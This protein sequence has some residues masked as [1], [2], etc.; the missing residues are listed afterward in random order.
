MVPDVVIGLPV[1]VRPVVP[2]ENATDVT[3]PEP[4]T[5]AHDVTPLPSVWR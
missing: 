4:L 3:V 1:T 2:P 5:A